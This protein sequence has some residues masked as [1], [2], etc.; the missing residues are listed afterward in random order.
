MVRPPLDL[1]LVLGPARV[2]SFTTPLRCEDLDDGKS[3]LI[4]EPFR[5]HAGTLDSDEIYVIPAGF[6]TDGA[7]IPRLLWPILGH[8]WG[9][10]GK[11][12]VL[13]DFLYRSG[14]PGMT[15]A[16]ADGLFL[17]AMAVLEIPEVRRRIIYLGVRVGGW[18]PW[19]RYRR[20]A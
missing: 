18:V 9:R 2:S 11:A 3:R 13:H 6:I 17:E 15:R 16:R 4:L 5:Y 7:S 20:I 19:N 10:P 8:P 14:F 12:A 1:V